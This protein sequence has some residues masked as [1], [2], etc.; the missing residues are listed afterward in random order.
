MVSKTD[1]IAR[2]HR[3]ILPLQGYKPRLQP[4]MNQELE[5]IARAF[6]GQQIPLGAIHEYHCA[7]RTDVAATTG[8]IAGLMHACRLHEGMIV[9][10]GRSKSIFPSALAYF[11]LRPEQ[12]IFITLA[13][14]MDRLWAIEAALKCSAIRAVVGENHQFSFQACRRYQ[15]AVE[16][17]GVTGFLIRDNTVAASACIARWKVRSQPS[18]VL[19]GLP[20][21]GFPRWQVDL[22]KARNG[23]PGSW[24]LSW[25][26]GK[27]REEMFERLEDPG[28]SK[29][30]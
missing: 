7:D 23:K 8:F 12:C 20:G 29:T 17:S 14:E 9:W 2:L 30:G 1:I 18:L 13:S 28:I 15:L 16:Q 5:C 4:A 24:Q 22:C 6:P 10:V 21:L 26:R 25:V 3:E 11:G 19:D 27:F